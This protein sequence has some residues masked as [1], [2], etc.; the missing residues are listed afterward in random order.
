VRSFF[1]VMHSTILLSALYFKIFF[2]H[3]TDSEI[4]YIVYVRY[5]I[6][7]AIRNEALLLES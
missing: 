6:I 7:E 2:F 4:I 1:K 3:M 5:L